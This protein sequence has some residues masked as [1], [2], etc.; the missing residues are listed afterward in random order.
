MSEPYIP[1]APLEQMAV[2]ITA[3]RLDADGTVLPQVMRKR[4]NLLETVR[5]G[6][7]ITHERIPDYS[8]DGWLEAENRTETDSERRVWDLSLQRKRGYVGW[9]LRGCNE[10]GIQTAAS[11]SEDISSVENKLPQEGYRTSDGSGFQQ[12]DALHFTKTGEPGDF[13]T[14]RIYVSSGDLAFTVL[15]K[16]LEKTDVLPIGGKVW[17]PGGNRTDA[18]ILYVNTHDQLSSILNG[19]YDL[20]NR[21]ELT[22]Y[23]SRYALGRAVVGLDGVYVAQTPP[24]KSFNGVMADLLEPAF[25]EAMLLYNVKTGKKLPQGWHSQVARTAASIAQ[26]NAPEYGVSREH[27]AFLK[28]ENVPAILATIREAEEL[29]A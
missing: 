20:R 28:G 1:L 21:R 10:A 6:G 23:P 13:S 18:P 29:L 2:V 22:L 4:L 12:G 8:E 17:F 5:A 16:L 24:G 11:G 3:E 27:H 9:L 26:K 7:S 19:L 25:V 14:T 15:R